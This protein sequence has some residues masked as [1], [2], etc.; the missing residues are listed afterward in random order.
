MKSKTVGQDLYLEREVKVLK[1]CS[2]KERF[3]FNG[4]IWIL[5][6]SISKKQEENEDQE[7]EI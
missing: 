2:K 3:I 6:Q 1:T 7:S 4:Q 5:D